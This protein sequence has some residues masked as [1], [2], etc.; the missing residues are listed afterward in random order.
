MLTLNKISETSTTLT[1][2]WTPPQGV[3]GYVFYAAGAA[4]STGSPNLKDGSP[5]KSIKFD[6]TRSPF[7][8]AATCYRSGQFA[9]EVGQYPGASATIYPS[10]SLYPS[11][12]P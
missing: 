5:R 3:G 12:T 1:L 6:K 7:A 4:V 10:T 2:G 11:E 9:L 8:V